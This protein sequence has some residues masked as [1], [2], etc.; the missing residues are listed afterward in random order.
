[1][2]TEI[3]GPFKSPFQILAQRTFSILK[4]KEA[5]CNQEGIPVQQQS[6]FSDGRLLS[7][8]MEVSELSRNLYMAPINSG[9]GDPWTITVKIK[10]EGEQKLSLL[11]QGSTTV[12]QIKELL[13]KK[14]NNQ[15]GSIKLKFNGNQLDEGSMKISLLKIKDKDILNATISIFFVK[16]IHDKVNYPIE[17]PKA[18]NTTIKELKKLIKRYEYAKEFD[19][20][21]F[22]T[23]DGKKL[24]D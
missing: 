12:F 6:I 20:I 9:G 7:D 19:I 24:D 8:F 4:L 17:L 10:G 14:L 11:N 21:S 22:E 5:I 16:A 18:N 3:K 1:M 2:M 23:L 13:S 15:I